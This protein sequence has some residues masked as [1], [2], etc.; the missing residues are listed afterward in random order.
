MD[1]THEEIE[2]MLGDLYAFWD[3]AFGVVQNLTEDGVE[4]ENL[5]ELYN[6]VEEALDL[7]TE[8][9]NNYPEDEE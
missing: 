1:Y 8:I 9:L 5:S 4:I 7:S 3:D 2:E 6:K